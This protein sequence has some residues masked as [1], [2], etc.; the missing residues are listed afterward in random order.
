MISIPLNLKNEIEKIIKTV[1]LNKIVKILT[2]FTNHLLYNYND[3][4]FIQSELNFENDMNKL[5]IEVILESIPLIDELFLNSSF[6]KQ[7]YYI[8]DRNVIRNRELYYGT[9]LYERNYY[10]DKTKKNGFYFI[11]ELFG[12]E[13]YTQYDQLLRGLFINEAV[14]TNANQ[15]SKNKLLNNHTIL[16]SLNPNIKSLKQVPR[17]TI[18]RWINKWEIPTVKFNPIPVNSTL[19]IMADEK[20]IHKQMKKELKK[21]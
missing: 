14:N 1:F 2:S 21:R 3:N 19:Y 4:M 6:R 7:H 9:L 20:W 10:V 13:K 5:F 16:D 8:S 12:F 17:Q 11:D 15:A 18:Y